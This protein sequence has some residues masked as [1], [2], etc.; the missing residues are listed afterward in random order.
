MMITPP[1]HFL[2]LAHLD[3]APSDKDLR[4]IEGHRVAPQIT[5]GLDKGFQV[6]EAAY[7]LG[8]L[9]YPFYVRCCS[10]R[11]SQTATGC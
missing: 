4:E 11:V 10:L 7:H 5:L 3:S 8:S 6:D 2:L 1:L 9:Y